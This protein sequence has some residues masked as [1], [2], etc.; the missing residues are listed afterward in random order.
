MAM[1]KQQ[2]NVKGRE[3]NWVRR[4]AGWSESTREKNIEVWKTF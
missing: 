1:K 3:G 4:I 2:H